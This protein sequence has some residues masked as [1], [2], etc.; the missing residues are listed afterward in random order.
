M[1]SPDETNLYLSGKRPH[2]T[3][4][5]NLRERFLKRLQ[6][7]E[8]D[9]TPVG[10]TTTYGVVDFMKSCGFERPLADTDPVAMTELAW[11]GHS[12]GGF[13]WV[14]SM[15]WDITALSEALGCPL[16]KPQIDHQFSI[17][18]HPFEESPQDL[19]FPPDFLNRGRFPVYKKHF[20]LLKRKAGDALV[21]FGET[22]GAFTCAANLVGVDQ[23]IRWCLKRPEV[24][25]QVLD[26]AKKAA[27]A[28]ANYAFDN[29]IDY[30]VF[31]EP[32]SGPAL[33]GPWLYEK[34]V[35]PLEREIIGAIAG[36]VVLHV[37]G[38]TD[39]IIDQMCDTG[40]A[41]ISIE[42]KTDLRRAVDIAHA[43]RIKVFGNVGNAALDSTPEKAYQEAISALENGTDFLCPGC[44]V[45]PRTPME[46][47][48]Q[49]KKAR[50]DFWG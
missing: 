36:P 10:C 38:N 11:A 1:G 28:A 19:A 33:L 18:G 31:A 49:L 23:L 3:E 20:E 48:Q 32:T 5:M 41:G 44:G 40:A 4:A 47:I 27:V 14:K 45:A 50:D 17:K 25:L 15:G 8:V 7:Q 6:G 21:I 42:E 46:N 34:F 29:G 9:K 24:A 37:C 22:E 2:W 13:E 30:F 26:V 39:L 16:G 35:L 12:F 43:R